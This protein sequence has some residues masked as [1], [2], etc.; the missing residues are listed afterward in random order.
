MH[1]KDCTYF[2]EKERNNQETLNVMPG[3][4]YQPPPKTNNSGV[5]ARYP[6]EIPKRDNQFCG[7]YSHKG[8]VI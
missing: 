6:Q 3:V 2:I 5:C 1:C 8:R 4:F 7:E